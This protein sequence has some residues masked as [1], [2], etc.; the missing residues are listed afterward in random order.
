MK[1]SVRHGLYM[2]ISQPEPRSCWYIEWPGQ[3]HK[4]LMKNT[5]FRWRDAVDRAFRLAEGREAR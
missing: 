1:Y 3:T 2:S 5:F 4:D